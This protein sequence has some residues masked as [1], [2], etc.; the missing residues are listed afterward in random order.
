MPSVVLCVLCLCM[1]KQPEEMDCHLCRGRPRNLCICADISERRISSR[2]SAN[3]RSYLAVIPLRLAPFGLKQ[4][5]FLF[6]RQ[7]P[8][9]YVLTHL[10]IS[11]QRCNSSNDRAGHAHAKQTMR[12][13]T[14]PLRVSLRSARKCTTIKERQSRKCPSNGQ[15]LQCT[16][17]ASLL[18]HG[19]P[20]C[21]TPRV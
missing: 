10:R 11:L 8:I 12:K 4:A 18:S 9:V 14:L 13:W 2:C 19:L 3:F 17:H 5:I 7:R 21:Q 20:K 1:V 15:S 16:S 6:V